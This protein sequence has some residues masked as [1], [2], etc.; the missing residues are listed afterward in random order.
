MTPYTPYETALRV[1]GFGSGAKPKSVHSEAPTTP[2]SDT[3]ERR[4]WGLVNAWANADNAGKTKAWAKIVKY[5][6]GQPDEVK[7]TAERIDQ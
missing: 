6:Q 2:K 7:I 1:L 5:N 4:A 3:T